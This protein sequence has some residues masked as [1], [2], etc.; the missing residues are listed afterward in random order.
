MTE[1][2]PRGLNKLR[3]FCAPGKA[4]E[5]RSEIAKANMPTGVAAAIAQTSAALHELRPLGGDALET[6]NFIEQLAFDVLGDARTAGG[7][8]IWCFA[9]DAT[10]EE[11]DGQI[12]NPMS[13]L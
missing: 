3:K 5:A 10:N 4:A 11:K 13:G 1:R 7:L 9:D 8:L 6:C 12:P 2:Y